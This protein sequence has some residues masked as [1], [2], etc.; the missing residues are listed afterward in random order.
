MEGIKLNGPPV[1]EKNTARIDKQQKGTREAKLK[2]ACADFEAI[3]ITQM[4]KAMRRTI[5]QSGLNK[6][7]GKDIYTMMFDRK[8]AEDLAKRD[9]GMGLQKAIFDQL[10]K[11]SR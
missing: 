8:V 4:F 9:G 10:N 3:F 6:F 2:K 1:V 7:P 5:P 11:R